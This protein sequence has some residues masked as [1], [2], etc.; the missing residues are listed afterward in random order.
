MG[1]AG[2][3]VFRRDHPNILGN[4]ARNGLAN[5]ETFRVDAVVVGDQ[6]AH[7]ASLPPLAAGRVVRA[8]RGP[9]GGTF[10]RHRRPPP[11]PSPPRAPRAGGGRRLSRSINITWLSNL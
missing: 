1:D 3:I 10:S 11:Q 5:V 7:Q 4:F 6:N 8:K 9:G 2:L